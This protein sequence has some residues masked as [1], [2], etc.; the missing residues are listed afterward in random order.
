MSESIFAVLNYLFAFA[1]PFTH[2]GGYITSGIAFI[3]V[4]SYYKELKTERLL[5]Y[6]VIFLA[7]GLLRALV[8]PDP[9]TGC[10][11]MVGYFC[12]WLLPFMLGFSLLSAGNLKKA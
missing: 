11:V 5:H 4:W 8:S 7:Y 9:K 3:L 10:N 1:M 2:I 6:L 12:H